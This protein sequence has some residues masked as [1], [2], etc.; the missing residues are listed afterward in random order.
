[1]DMNMNTEVFAIAKDIHA[2]S[3][4]NNDKKYS[5]AMSQLLLLSLIL[6]VEL[7]PSWL[8]C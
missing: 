1:M 8:L 2:L 4:H 5:T 7:F 6:S 3:I